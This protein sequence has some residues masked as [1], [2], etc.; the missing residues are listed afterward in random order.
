MIGNDGLSVKC[1]RILEHSKEISKRVNW[2]WSWSDV[3]A[4]PLNVSQTII[5]LSSLPDTAVVPFGEKTQTDTN[6]HVKPLSVDIAT[7]LPSA[8]ILTHV[9]AP[10]CPASVWISSPV[11]KSHTIKLQ[12]FDPDIT[13][14]LLVTETATVKTASEWPTRTFKQIIY[15]PPHNGTA[16]FR[17]KIYLYDAYLCQFSACC[18]PHLQRHVTRTRDNMERVSRYNKAGDFVGVADVVFFFFSR[19]RPDP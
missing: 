1:T 10:K 11:C 15:E 2:T 6:T 8:E 17:D 16:I 18:L 5:V 19:Q 12:S 9:T 3:K 13:W 14:L 7:F 4:N